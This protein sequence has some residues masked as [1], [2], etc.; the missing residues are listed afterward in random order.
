MATCE[1]CGRDRDDVAAYT[2]PMNG[3]EHGEPVTRQLCTLCETSILD[4]ALVSRKEML[5][6]RGLADRRME[7]SS[8]YR[9]QKII[10]YRESIGG[11][12]LWHAQVVLADGT[13]VYLNEG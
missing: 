1:S 4:E 12:H 3:E 7:A 2:R 11:D 9:G 5:R 13:R 8:L 10:G 6:V